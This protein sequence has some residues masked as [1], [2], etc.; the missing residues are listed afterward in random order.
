MHVYVD[1]E[2]GALSSI[3]TLEEHMGSHVGSLY[4]DVY[5]REV[6]SDIVHV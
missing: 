1:H 5:K 6:F 4:S 2:L 3:H